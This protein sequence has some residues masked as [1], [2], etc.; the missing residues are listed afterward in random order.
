MDKNVEEYL[1]KTSHRVTNV[2]DYKITNVK[3]YNRD[4][5]IYCTSTVVTKI[6]WGNVFV[7]TRLEEHH[8]RFL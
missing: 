5:S 2:V 1:A 8:D 7:T 4:V 3:D 6:S